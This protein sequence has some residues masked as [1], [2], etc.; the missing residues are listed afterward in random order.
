MA[1]FRW[2]V[3]D[4]MNIL[5][6]EQLVD[7]LVDNDREE[8]NEK[9]PVAKQQ[10]WTAAEERGFLCGPCRNTITGTVVS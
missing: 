10:I 4:G 5:L 2:S 6:N 1:K 9:T 8:S 3:Y 7:P